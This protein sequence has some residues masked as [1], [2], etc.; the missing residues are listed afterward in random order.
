MDITSVSDY[1]NYLEVERALSKNTIEA[2]EN[3]IF[4]FLEYLS[5]EMKIQEIN[6][7]KRTHIS[8]FNR[9]LAASGIS[10]VSIVRKIA[11]IKGFFRYLCINSIIE[12]NPALALN[13]PKISKK[14]PKV[15]SIKE[16]E[17][18]LSTHLSTTEKALFE[19]FYATGLRVSE[20]VNLEIKNVNLKSGFIKTMGKGSKERIIPIGSKA[21]NALKNYLKEREL[22]ILTSDYGKKNDKYVFLRTNGT[23]I[24]R[25]YVYKFIHNLGKKIEKNISP[26]TIRHSFATHLLEN[27]ADL[28][29]V[30]ELLG[31][32][33]IVTT[34]LYTH[35]SK[36]RLREVYFSI[37]SD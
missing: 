36:K 35:I 19:L 37:N 1:I 3:D 24:T 30:Q 11:S 23:K 26:H 8:S 17:K 5:S 29:V 27:G 22:I 20:L 18:L 15:I 6:Q 34:Q 31:H 25:Q 33:S 2:Y 7:I 21:K 13:S 32:S 28:R 16:I 4:S 12:K 14:L 10:P 9:H